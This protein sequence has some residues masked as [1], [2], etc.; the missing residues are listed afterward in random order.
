MR[1]N[2]WEQL[3]KTSGSRPRSVLMMDG[4]PETV[5]MRLTNLIGLEGT[6]VL[7]QG[8]WM[9]QGKP[10]QNVDRSWD[11]SP[12]NEAK[13]SSP[14]Q[15]IDET[16]QTEL[17]SWWLEFTGGANVPNWDIASQCIVDGV[18][19]LLLI[20][21]KAHWGEL[22]ENPT[23]KRPP[24]TLNGWTNHKK[25]GRA[26]T[27]ASAELQF[28]TKLPW[29]ISRDKCYQLSNRFAWSWK[30]ASLGIPVVLVYLGFLNASE[31]PEPLFQADGE[32]EH[33]WKSTVLKYSEGLVPSKAWEDDY[34]IDIDDVPII[35]LIRTYDQPFPADGYQDSKP[36]ELDNRAKP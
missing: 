26:I 14:N 34:R 27:D 15:L 23:G 31:M 6:V 33:S 24:T 13:L 22:Q 1:M 4:A 3:D 21:A 5:A 10:A 25:I 12:A 7:P 35:P 30:L 20:E 18:D 9:P 11:K 17:K 28:A 32:G 36:P 8:H 19:G 2:W 16:I 29:G